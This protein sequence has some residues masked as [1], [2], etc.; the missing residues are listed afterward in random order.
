M[1]QRTAGA[2]VN[3]ERFFLMTVGL[4]LLMLLIIAAVARYIVVAPILWVEEIIVYI[5][6][7]Y[8]IIGAVYSTYERTYI[9]GGVMHLVLKSP[10][11][12]GYLNIVNALIPL[13]L[14]CL[15][16]VWGFQD[17]IWNLE[18]KST[19]MMLYLPLEWAHLSIFA[20]FSLMALYFFKEL[21]DSAHYSFKKVRNA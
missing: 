16:S 15:F 9:K 6:F 4:V 14:C 17:F 12:R 8:Y 1:F 7:W 3:L 18:F 21:I 19:T 10:K 2:L 11:A 20:G 13:A 5:V